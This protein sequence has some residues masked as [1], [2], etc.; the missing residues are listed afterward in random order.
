M[1]EPAVEL[2][3][4]RTAHKMQSLTDDLVIVDLSQAG[5]AGTSITMR[6]LYVMLSRVTSL[7]GLRRL[8]HPSDAVVRQGR[9]WEHLFDLKWPLELRRFDAAYGDAAIHDPRGRLFQADFVR[10][11]DAQ[12]LAGAGAGAKEI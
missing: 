5:R 4:S 6:A 2:D 1:H 10:Q 8:P 11:Y 3:F 7:A 12:E 9:N